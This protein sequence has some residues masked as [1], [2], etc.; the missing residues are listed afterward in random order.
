MLGCPGNSFNLP[1]GQGLGQT[2]P[3]LHL[4]A[5]ICGYSGL[6]FVRYFVVFFFLLNF[7]S[8]R[9]FIFFILAVIEPVVE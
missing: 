6:T 4:D 5:I 3:D 7:I 1:P 9:L 2:D 8:F